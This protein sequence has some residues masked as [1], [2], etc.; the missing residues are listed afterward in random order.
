MEDTPEQYPPPERL[1]QP[2]TVPQRLLMGPGPSNS[3]PRVLQV[4][5]LPLLGHLH[6]EFL[7]VMDDIQ[8]GIRYAFQTKNT[9]ALAVSACSSERKEEGE[10][11]REC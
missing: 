8:A 4:A 9:F 10:W 2:L 3:S 5:A 11:L 7:D 1:Q 6:P